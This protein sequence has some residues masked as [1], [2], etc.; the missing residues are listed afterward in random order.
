MKPGN[1]REL[2]GEDRLVAR[3]ERIATV[4][5]IFGGASALVMSKRLKNMG[6]TDLDWVVSDV[7]SASTGQRH[8]EHGAWECPECGTTCVGMDKAYQHCNE[9]QE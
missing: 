4:N 1:W 2:T 9:E 8:R 7:Y 5:T 6:G 3:M